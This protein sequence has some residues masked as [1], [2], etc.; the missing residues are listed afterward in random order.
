MVPVESYSAPYSGV[1]TANDANNIINPATIAAAIAE[2][3]STCEST[4]QKIADQIKTVEPDACDAVVVQRTNIGKKMEET[5]SKIKSLSNTMGNQFE[6]LVP[7][8]E[9]K[10]DEIQMQYNAAA[11]AAADAE[12]ER[13]RQE[14]MY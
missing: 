6:D 14:H 5:V 8:A 7:K 10:H 4:L 11:K 9:A 2:Y 1:I 13:Y 12:F 3:K